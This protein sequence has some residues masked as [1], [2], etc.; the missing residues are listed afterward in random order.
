MS[1]RC[2]SENVSVIKLPQLDNHDT[3][4]QS[5]NHRFYFIKQEGGDGNLQKRGYFAKFRTREAS[6]GFGQIIR[7]THL[8]YRCGEDRVSLSRE[9]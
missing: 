4:L 9:R 1:H 6:V 2:I 8:Y 5:R 7:A 3:S